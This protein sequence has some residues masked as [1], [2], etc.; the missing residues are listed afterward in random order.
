MRVEQCTDQWVQQYVIRNYFITNSFIR[1]ILVA[2]FSS[3]VVDLINNVGY[4]SICLIELVLRPSKKW[5]PHN[6]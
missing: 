3:Q 4:D 5:L 2:S 6:L 1:T